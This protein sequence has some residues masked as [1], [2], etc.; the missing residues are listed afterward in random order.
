MS[1]T[2]TVWLNTKKENVKLPAGQDLT[3][4]I[5][6]GY[7]KQ[8]RGKTLVRDSFKALNQKY[9]GKNTHFVAGMNQTAEKIDGS[10]TDSEANRNYKIELKLNRDQTALEVSIVK[11]EEGLRIGKATNSSLPKKMIFTKVK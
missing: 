2:D 3:A 8:A 7:F 4:D 11:P 9:S 10:L 5:L 1:K 6:I